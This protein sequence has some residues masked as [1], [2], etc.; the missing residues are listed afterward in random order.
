LAPF[1]TGDHKVI[2][3]SRPFDFVNIGF[4]PVRHFYGPVPG[5]RAEIFNR[6]VGAVD[7]DRP[8]DA[9]GINPPDAEEVVFN[10]T[11]EAGNKGDEDGIRPACPGNHRGP[12]N[13]LRKQGG[14][15]DQEEAHKK[16]AFLHIIIIIGRNELR[17]DKISI[18]AFKY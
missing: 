4:R 7:K 10:L 17:P 15:Q 1:V 6:D 2:Q 9:G 11:L 13:I 18:F 12:G 3:G 16:P 14:L 8:P 5:S